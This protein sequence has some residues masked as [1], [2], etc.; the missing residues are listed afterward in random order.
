MF[1]RQSAVEDCYSCFIGRKSRLLNARFQASSSLIQ[2][3]RWRRGLGGIMVGVVVTDKDCQSTHRALETEIKMLRL[4]RRWWKD[5]S[6]SLKCASL[7]SLFSDGVYGIRSFLLY[8]GKCLH[9]LNLCLT[10]VAP[11]LWV[12]RGFSWALREGQSLA[13]CWNNHVFYSAYFVDLRLQ[14]YKRYI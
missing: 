4:R 10:W 12:I 13:L 8:H 14:Q 7:S 3:D 2:W 9:F 1:P 5:L 11:P 6:V